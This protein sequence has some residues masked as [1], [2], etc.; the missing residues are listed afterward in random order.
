MGYKRQKYLESTWRSSEKKFI[1][2]T[3]N[4]PNFLEINYNN[5]IPGITNYFFIQNGKQFDAMALAKGSV[6]FEQT[7]VTSTEHIESQDIRFSC[8]PLPL[9]ST[10]F[11]LKSGTKG[12]M[13]SSFLI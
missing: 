7:G 8:Q 10:N 6:S 1:L 11:P 3:Q 12:R 13:P 5:I 2:E 9:F 4:I